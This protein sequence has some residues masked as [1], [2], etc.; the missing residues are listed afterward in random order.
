MITLEGIYH[1]KNH[2]KS[3]T[4]TLTLGEDTFTLSC[5]E[6]QE[7]GDIHSLSISA[8]IGNSDRTITLSDG[9][10]FQTPH[11]QD[12][13]KYFRPN[14]SLAFVSQLE[15]SWMGAGLAGLIL[16]LFVA[17]FFYTAPLLSKHIAF[18]LPMSVS[19][20]ISAGAM[21]VLDEKFLKPSTLSEQKQNEVR[22]EFLTLTQM[23][24]IAEYDYN[25]RLYFRSMDGIANAFILPSGEIVLT[26]ELI[27]LSKHSNEINAVL[28]HEMG[29]MLHKHILRK[30]ILSS[31]VTVGLSVAIGDLSFVQD[32][33]LLLP[34]ALVY[35]KFSRDFESEADEFA[36]SVMTQ[37]DI[38]PSNL[39][40]LLMR[41]STK[42]ANASGSPLF[43][44]YFATHPA[45]KLRAKM[46]EE[47]RKK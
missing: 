15:T 3:H 9:G 19:E 18:A 41:L 26:D 2:S 33:A 35:N 40:N 37:Q 16:V 39:T 47:Y 6:A 8:Q 44:G 36:F 46:A 42:D 31:I 4:A 10:I 43:G 28:L 24:L 38:A 21:K 23:A 30:M 27:N 29:H 22:Q 32:M 7:D 12:I 17:S 25:F 20:T 45:T 5:D 13:E 14:K 11:H 34:T 1:F